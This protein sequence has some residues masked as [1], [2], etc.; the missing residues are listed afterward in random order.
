MEEAAAVVVVAAPPPLL[1][2]QRLLQRKDDC[3]A[4]AAEDAPL[5]VA[6][7]LACALA[8]KKMRYEE[9]VPGRAMRRRGPGDGY[10]D[11]GDE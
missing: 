1:L 6:Q 10:E 7:D 3:A 5:R 11:G 2:P 8:G 9:R 4:A